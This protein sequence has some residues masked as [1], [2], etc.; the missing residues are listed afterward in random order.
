MN[1]AAYPRPAVEDIARLRRRIAASGLPGKLTDRNLLIGTWNIRAFGRVYEK[2]DENLG[3]PKRNLRAT[4]SIAEVIRQLDVVAIQEVK[5]DTAGIRRLVEEFLGPDWELIISDV[6]AG[7]EGN[8]ERLGF[9][10]DKRRVQPSG[11]AGEIVLPATKAGDPAEQ[12]ARTPYIVGFR[13]AG[14][15]FALLTAH[16]KYGKVPQDRIGEL[17]ELARYVAEEIRDRTTTD[18]GEESNL[19]VLGDFNIDERQGNPLFDA[20]VSTGLVV[21]KQLWGLKTT[22]DTKPKY[23]DQIAWFMGG[24]NL[25][26]NDRA[27]VVDIA[28]ALFKE[29]TL[30]QMSF[31]ISD[32]FPLWAEFSI[33]RST[34]SMAKTLGVDPAMPDPL[35]VVPD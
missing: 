2:W 25:I 6:A 27:G 3:S 1:Y 9:I 22:Y 11:L 8:T 19:I 26:F 30:K 28:G 7:S 17:R 18:G 29:L 15:S 24:L 35:S 23:Y 14:E 33:D 21:P 12:F 4:A 34:E 31:R 16:I 5:R 20:F 10:Y 32:H 13:S